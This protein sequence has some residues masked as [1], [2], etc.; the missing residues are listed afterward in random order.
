MNPERVFTVL[1]SPHVSE[2]STLRT[3]MDNQYVFR[4]DGTATKSEVKT[5]VEQLFKVKVTG[6]Q[7]LHVK[8]KLKR[9]RYGFSRKPS[10]KKAYVS[11]EQGHS[12]D[13]TVASAP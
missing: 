13:F 3:E 5:A 8:G 1:H 9:N 4:V 2:K 11:L 12:I 10:W 7:T 6:V